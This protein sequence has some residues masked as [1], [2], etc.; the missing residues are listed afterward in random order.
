MQILF[1]SITVPFPAID[2]GRIRVL[3]LLKQIAKTEQVTFL[4][5]ETT[6]TD[7]AGI[8]YLTE[9]GIECHLVP[10]SPDL[11]PITAQTV[12]RATWQRKPITVA[13]YDLP[14]LARQF[15]HLLANGD[16]AYTGSQFLFALPNFDANSEYQN[17]ELG[18]LRDLSL[19]VRD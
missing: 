19:A 6:G 15:H 11:P 17:H 8:D 14:A 1:F 4:A 10:N 13:R 5:L 12:L 3:N 16:R 7:Q 18:L 2:G 9:L